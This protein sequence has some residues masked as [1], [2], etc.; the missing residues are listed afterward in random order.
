MSAS[1][2]TLRRILI[3]GS[4]VSLTVAVVA[5][6]GLAASFIQPTL[7]LR[8]LYRIAS[9]TREVGFFFLGSYLI[10]GFAFLG[11][12]PTGADVAMSGW[13]WRVVKTICALCFV[14]I[15]LSPHTYVYPN[16]GGWITKSKAG[17]FNI[18]SGTA[19]EYLW[20]AVRMWSA[21][22]LCGSLYVITFTRQFVRRGETTIA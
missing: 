12:A 10:S 7:D 14:L 16:A 11:A 15:L 2:A 9:L 18:P 8:E 21:I 20:R 3:A 5:C 19:R 6:V 13:W 22:P 17:A 1:V 4:A